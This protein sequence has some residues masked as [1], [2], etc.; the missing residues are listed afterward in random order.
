MWY[1]LK[2]IVKT[3]NP[4]NKLIFQTHQCL[5]W[6]ILIPLN[7]VE[8]LRNKF[9]EKELEIYIVP[10]IRKNVYIEVYGFLKKEERELFLKLNTLSKIGPKLALNI[11]SVFSP[12]VLRNV[13]LERNVQELA[14][15]PGIGPKRAEKLF[16]ELKTLFLKTSFKGIT[17]PPEKEL[18]LEEAKSCLVGLGFSTKEIEKILYRVLTENDTLDTLIKKAL[19]ELAPSLPEESFK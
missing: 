3:V 17:L 6:G 5:C 11:L 16:L 1:S 18:L 10:I 9:K 2:G 19:K 4:P 13:V 12:E 14:K 15:V 8:L 7:K